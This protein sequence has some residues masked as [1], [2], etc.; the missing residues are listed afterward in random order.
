MLQILMSGLM[1][2]STL[3][4]SSYEKHIINV[5]Q[6]IHV[7]FSHKSHNRI[8]IEDGAVTK[9]I[10]DNGLFSV[11][12]DQTTGQAFVTLNQAIEE[13][14][15]LT[16]VSSTGA[17]QDLNVVSKDGPG[18]YLLLEDAQS[19]DDEYMDSVNFQAMAVDFLNRIL[20]GDTPIG[21]GVRDLSPDDVL[22][23]PNPLATQAVKALEGPL[24]DIVIYKI[25]NHGKTPVF[26]RP[27][28]IKK[29]H[30]SWVFL[31]GHELT[32]GTTV[33]CVV[34]SPKDGVAS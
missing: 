4:G 30:Q 25:S 10:G 20:I 9:I 17:I 21:Y 28:A 32:R 1:L 5:T 23:L 8:G 34:C 27:E 2:G 7:Q 15:T 33:Y 31:T 12:I 18:Q 29:A 22:V 13:Q 26:L 11:T 19:C 6:P 14:S 3:Q 16:V 24:D